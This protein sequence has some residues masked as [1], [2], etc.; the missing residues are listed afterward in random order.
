MM[1]EFALMKTTERIDLKLRSLYSECGYRPFKMARFEEYDLYVRNRDFIPREDIITIPG[2]GGKLLAL[3]PDLTLSIVK[4]YR[5]NTEKPEKVYYSETVFRADPDGDFREL[6]QTGLECIGPLR[7]EDAAEVLLL[8]ARSLSC[9]SNDFVLEL[10]HMGFLQACLQDVPAAARPGI[11]KLLGG[12]NAHELADALRKADVKEETAARITRI[13]EL[14]GNAAEVLATL[15]EEKA[16]FNEEQKGY[17]RELAAAVEKLAAAGFAYRVNIDFSI[18][19]NMTY[20]SGLIF[21]GYVKGITQSILSGGRYDGLMKRMGKRGGAIGFAL[22]LD[23]LE[24]LEERQ[25]EEGA[26]DRMIR[27]ALPKGRLGQK[28]YE[29]F[30]ACG[31]GLEDM[32]QD[33]RKLVFQDPEKGIS[34]FWVKPSDVTVYVERGAA[35]LGIAGKDI[36]DEYRP[37]VYELLDLKLGKCR[38]CVA[39]KEDFQDDLSRTLTVA[40]KFPRTARAHFARESRD[41]DVVELHGSIELA[42]LLGL[43]DVIVDIVETG[44]TLYENGLTVIDQVSAIS[45]RLIANKASCKFKGGVIGEIVESLRK[46][47]ENE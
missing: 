34:F 2:E 5:D 7:D 12:K 28:V 39:A 16:S 13:L 14:N 29:L 32:D 41:I 20:Y 18:V 42:P 24:E 9:V 17:L 10:S 8:A 45:A 3:R 40:T 31:Y 37:D 30:C 33:S 15:T 36:I 35:D 23:P 44:K 11:L 26:V 47:V 6:R 22:Y 1:D 43:S 4:N 21:R 25:P 27:V 46:E 19:N 38:M